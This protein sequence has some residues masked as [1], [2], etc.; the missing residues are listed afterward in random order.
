MESMLDDMDS[1][2]QEEKFAE[3][4]KISNKLIGE[5]DSVGLHPLIQPA[6]DLQEMVKSNDPGQGQERL[7]FLKDL[8]ERID[9]GAEQTKISAQVDAGVVAAEKST[10]DESA[11]G[12]SPQSAGAPV[13]SRLKS[14]SPES[15]ERVEQF[16]IRLSS[17]LAEIHSA[18]EKQDF[19][20]I[21]KICQWISRY[22]RV[23]G[24]DDFVQPADELS[25]LAADAAT[26][27]ISEKLDE[28]GLLFARIEV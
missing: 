6:K 28:L 11:S 3:L 9:L 13:R 16:I 5:A 4:I 8:V 27:E 20:D 14:D 2:L 10:A 18:F 7:L 1:A 24:Y 25:G 26:T 15:R 21:V 17:R 19:P 23:L 22:S 12:T